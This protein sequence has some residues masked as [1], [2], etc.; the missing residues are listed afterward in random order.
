MKGKRYNR[1]KE[2]WDITSGDF[3]VIGYRTL[4]LSTKTFVRIQK[5]EEKKRGDESSRK[6]IRSG[7]ESGAGIGKAN[8]GRMEIRRG[9]A[10]KKVRRVLGTSRIWKI[11]N[12]PGQSGGGRGAGY[13]I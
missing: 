9:R 4:M 5:K 2:E 12:W 8:R 7:K 10:N 13:H 1:I 6:M 11:D 3:F